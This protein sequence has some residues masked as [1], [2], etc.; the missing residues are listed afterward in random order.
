MQR[1][2]ADAALAG[3]HDDVGALVGTEEIGIAE[4][5]AQSGW[6][7]GNAGIVFI[8]DTKVSFLWNISKFCL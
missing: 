3:T 1:A 5:V 6:T 4:V 7:I 8:F 2:A